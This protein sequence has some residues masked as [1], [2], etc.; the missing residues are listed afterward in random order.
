MNCY[1]GNTEKLIRHA[2]SVAEQDK[3]VLFID[4]ADSFLGTR[5]HAHHSW[6]ISFVNEFLTNM[7]NFKGMLICATNFKKVMDSASI[8]RFNLKVQ[9]D[10]LNPSGAVL[11]YERFF[12]SLAEGELPEDIKPELIEMSNLAPGDFKTVYQKYSLF[13]KSELTHRRIVD[14]L[15]EELSAKDEKFGKKMGFGKG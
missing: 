12:K 9:F 6:E 10:F 15:W 2:F 4:E 1:V 5:E 8:R 14:A 11:F 3:A 13:D 7:E